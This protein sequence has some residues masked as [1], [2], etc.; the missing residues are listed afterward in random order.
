MVDRHHILIGNRTMK[1]LAIALSGA[2]ER[3]MERD[4]GGDLTNVQ[5]KPIQNC[6][7][8]SLPVQWIY[9]NE[10][11]IKLNKENEI[12]TWKGPHAHYNTVHKSQEKE[13]KFKCQS[14]NTAIKKMSCIYSMECYSTSKEWDPVVCNTVDR[15]RDHSVKWNKPGTKRQAL[16]SF[17]RGICRGWGRGKI[18]QWA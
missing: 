4:S 7:N 10:N 12:S 17:I 9:P 6:H 3:L 14:T 1:P 15:T 16:I 2:G 5:Y 11:K 13:T 8:E 18:D